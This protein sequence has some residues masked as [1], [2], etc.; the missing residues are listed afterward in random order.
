MTRQLIEATDEEVALEWLHDNGR[1]DGLP[2]VIPT[3]ARVDRMVLASGIDGSLDVGPMGPGNGATTIEAIA[4]NAVMAGCR[5]DDMPVVLAT[6][7]AIMQTP[8]DLTEVQG[9]T[10]SIAP[11][12]IVCGPIAETLGISS[13]F[14]ALGPGHRAN[15]SIGRAVRLCMMNIGGARPGVSDMALLGHGGKFSFCMAEDTVSSPWEPLH[16]SLGYAAED[17]A[18]IVVG[19]EAPHSAVFVADA[20]DPTS[21]DRL[22]DTVAAVIA[23]VGSN[24]AYFRCGSVAV[25]FNP[26]HVGVLEAAEL[27]RSDVQQQ[28]FERATNTRA[29]LARLNPAFAGRGQP[30]D[31]I[32]AVADPNDLLV[33]VAGG[34]GLYTSV[35]PSWGAGGH[36]N[37]IV[38]HPITTDL[39]CEIPTFAPDHASPSNG[40][41]P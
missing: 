36:N 33:F 28:L 20:D 22:L 15:A 14:G 30:D 27:S 6:V 19:T 13:G 24:N 2:V 21:T 31:T 25:A 26:E 10:H 38:S 3:A 9:T 37:P 35:F 11:L 29:T 39:A 8:F 4:T 12:S 32:R 16:T 41:T 34:P 40:A 23:N 5:P 18:V 1:T 7:Q 17:S